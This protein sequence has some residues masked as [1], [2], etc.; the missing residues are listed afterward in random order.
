MYN[1]FGTKSNVD[2]LYLSR[3]EGGRGFIGVQSLM[4]NQ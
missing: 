4:I 3:S 1:E 2:R